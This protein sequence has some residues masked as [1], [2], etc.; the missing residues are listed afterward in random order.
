MPRTAPTIYIGSTQA[1]LPR[2][3]CSIPAQGIHPTLL[4]HLTL[5]LMW[6]PTYLLRLHLYNSM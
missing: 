2:G 1:L 3:Q 4:S 6:L 5:W